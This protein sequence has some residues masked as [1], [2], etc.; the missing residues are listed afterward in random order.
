MREQWIAAIGQKV[1]R[2]W[3]KPSGSEKAPTC[4]IIVEQLPGGLVSDVRFSACDWGRSYRRS[5]EL[6]VYKA[7]PLP[8]A[9]DPKIFDRT[10]EFIF[11]QGK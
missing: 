1:R 3:L 7:E 9:P 4:K 6:A 10:I 5:V 2:N 11:D 8:S